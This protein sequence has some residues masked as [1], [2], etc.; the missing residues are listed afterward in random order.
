MQRLFAILFL[1]IAL[2]LA[3]ALLI[4]ITDNKES[5]FKDARIALLTNKIAALQEEAA[6]RELDAL[7]EPDAT[8]VYHGVGTNTL[9]G[10][11]YM[12]TGTVYNAVPG[13]TDDSPLTTA[14]NSRI[15]LHDLN[16][17]NLR[18]CALSRDLLSRW[19]GPFNYGDLIMVE[20]A[21]HMNG[22]WA[23]HDTMNK[24]YTNYIDFLV[25]EHIKLGKWENI[26]IRLVK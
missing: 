3:G 5:D 6:N 22:I 2:L 1:V 18:W 16:S 10:D 4:V 24:R 21:G 13:Q 9:V 15:D 23:V 25:P 20:G 12:L 7:L 26:S 19:D 8:E 17:G 11:T 14:D